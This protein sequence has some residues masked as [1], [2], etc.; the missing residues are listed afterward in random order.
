MIRKR[1]GPGWKHIAGPV[2]EHTSG[3]RIHV[4]GMA[5]LP[6]GVW[7]NG[8]TWPEHKALDLCIRICGGTRR[9]GVMVWALTKATERK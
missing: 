8:R 4:F 6:S 1:P 5:L 2:Y 9:R 3:I 7:I